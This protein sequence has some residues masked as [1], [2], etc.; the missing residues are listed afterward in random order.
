MNQKTY[1]V[2]PE[3]VAA[4]RNEAAANGVT[5]S[6]GN[7]GIVTDSKDHVTLGFQYDGASHLV[8][9]ISSKP[10]YAPDSMIW[11]ALDKYIAA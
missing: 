9:T 1:T 2:T 5:V 3:Q 4:F 10:W 8:L 7:S 11:T 6:P